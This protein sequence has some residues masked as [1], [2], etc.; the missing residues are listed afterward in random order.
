MVSVVGLEP[1]K[2]LRLTDLKT[3]AFTISPHAHIVE[4]A[5]A[6]STNYRKSILVNRYSK[7]SLAMIASVISNAVLHVRCSKNPTNSF[8]F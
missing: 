6:A 2:F 8:S 5:I 7:G 3:A 4:A 1:T